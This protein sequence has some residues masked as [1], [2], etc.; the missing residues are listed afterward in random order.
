M[1]WDS[2]RNEAK[3]HLQ[4]YLRLAT[5]NPPG[6]EIAGARFFEA[7]FNRESIPVRIFEPSPGRASVMATLKGDGTQKPLLLLSHIDVVPVD[8]E[9]WKI[10]PF[11]GTIHDGF[12]YGRGALD[13]KSMG[14][15]GM[16]VMLLLKKERVPLKRDILFLAAADEETGGT[17]GIEWAMEHL[18]VLREVEF[19]LN[20]G[21]YVMLDENGAVDRYEISYG[22]K[23]LCQLKLTVRGTS[24]HGSMP[25]GDNPNV[26]LV[27]ALDRVTRWETPVRI[28]PM[29]REYFAKMAPKQS[30]EDRPFYE[31]I[32]KGLED[33]SFLKKLTSNPSYNAVLRDTFSLNV[34]QGGKKINVIPS[35]STALLDCRLLPGTPKDAFL[36]ELQRHFGEGVEVDIVSESPSLPPSPFDT[37]L[38]KAIERFAAR[39]DPGAPVVPLLLPGATDSRFLREKGVI[40]Y[41]FCPFRLSQKELMLVHGDNERIAVENLEFGIKL[42]LEVLREVAA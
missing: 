4:D 1:N 32:E 20:E 11:S 38:F 19:A 42:M 6:N 25:H 3:H 30:P 23:T 9:K 41:D 37:P 29:V 7:I 28:L 27:R 10:D 5:V 40:A 17:W 18:P 16:M 22:Q 31:D 24:G 35:E 34:L 21:G 12:L 2:L 15:V 14:I 13:D 39:H 26:K 33:P 8:R 36:K